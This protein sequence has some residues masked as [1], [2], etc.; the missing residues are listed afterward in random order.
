MLLDGDGPEELPLKMILLPRVAGVAG[1]ASRRHGGGGCARS[2]AEFVVPVSAQ[3]DAKLSLFF[4]P[5]CETNAAFH[6]DLGTDTQNIAAL[7]RQL[8]EEAP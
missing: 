6:L 3:G 2:G 4:G 8:L 7:T 5:D 1:H